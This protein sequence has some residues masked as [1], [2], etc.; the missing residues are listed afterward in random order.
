[1]KSDAW[2]SC[3][4][5]AWDAWRARDGAEFDRLIRAAL[6]VRDRCG[7]PYERSA[8]AAWPL[9]AMIERDRTDGL[10][11]LMNNA[12]ETIDAIEPPISRADA[13]FLIWQAIHPI[14]KYR[15]QL[16]PMQVAAC[17]AAKS[18]KGYYILSEVI[19]IVAADDPDAARALAAK[20]ADGKEK[21]ATLRKLDD[22]T[23][24]SP[25]P[26]FWHRQ[27]SQRNS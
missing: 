27:A 10:G 17:H 23:T 16:L 8:V 12:V 6:K 15:E 18:W 4:E 25:R 1:M 22:G 11:R 20:M 14:K 5:L 2:K 26:F 21:R 9:R 3:L 24:L 7:D 13:L 19:L